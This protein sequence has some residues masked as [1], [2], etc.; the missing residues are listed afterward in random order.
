MRRSLQ[1][2]TGKRLREARSRFSPKKRKGKA[3]TPRIRRQ[4]GRGVIDNANPF[5]GM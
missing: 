2:E 1:T 4:V 5:M 3:R